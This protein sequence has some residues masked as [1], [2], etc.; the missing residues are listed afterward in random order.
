MSSKCC[1]SLFSYTITRNIT[2]TC[3]LKNTQC[4]QQIKFAQLIWK[5]GI[6][7][8]PKVSAITYIASTKFRQDAAKRPYIYLFIIW[9]SQDNLWSPVGPRL[10]VGAEMIRLKTTTPKINDLHLTPTVAFHQY[11]LGFQVTMY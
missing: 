6:H 3:F 4:T 2:K 5:L 10:N 1:N 7:Y 8:K 9:K 11:V